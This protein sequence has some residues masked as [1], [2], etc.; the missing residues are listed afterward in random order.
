MQRRLA[1]ILG[2]AFCMGT[3]A[4]RFGG[5]EPTQAGRKVKNQFLQILYTRDILGNAE[6][7]GCSPEQK[8]GLPRMATVFHERQKPNLA[9]LKVDCGNFLPKSDDPWADIHGP[10]TIRG[11]QALGYDAINVGSV[12]AGY[13]VAELRKLRDSGLPLVSANIGDAAG[14]LLFSPWRVITKGDFKIAC[15]GL[16]AKGPAGEGVQLLPTEEAL[17]R[18]QPLLA[19][20]KPDLVCILGDFTVNEAVA[21]ARNSREAHV[22]LSAKDLKFAPSTNAFIAPA[23]GQ[24]GSLI[25]RADLRR[26]GPTFE[27]EAELLPLTH[28]IAADAAVLKLVKEVG[29]TARRTITLSPH[30]LGALDDFANS[31]ACKTCHA[32]EYEIW[33]ASRH[34]HAFD[35]L[36]ER[37]ATTRIDCVACHV[38]GYRKRDAG[39]FAEHVGCES[40]HGPGRKHIELMTT[41]KGAGAPLRAGK[42]SCQKCHSELNS[43]IFTFEYYWSKIQH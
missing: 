43:P 17:K 20:E 27:F 4:T 6:L 31:L 2:L 40:C 41:G 3:A 10:Q 34:S 7:C 28:A 37:E 15:I 9:T 16:S 42:E 35:I 5:D 21:V 1:V 30:R 11:Y 39:Y 14:R 33:E 18:L 12:E 25:G 24:Y 38:T 13:S 8:G 32:R 23:S 22:I 26:N 29:E 36:K 19:K